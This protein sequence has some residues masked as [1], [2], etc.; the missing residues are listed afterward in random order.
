MEVG[1]AFDNAIR[2]GWKNKKL[3]LFGIAA[4]YSYSSTSDSDSYREI[5]LPVID[6][7]AVF[8]FVGLLTATISSFFAFGLAK[9][10]LRLIK[11]E[12]IT[13]KGTLEDA[14]YFF[15]R[16]LVI[17]MVGTIAGIA[18]I[19]IPAMAYSGLASFI[20]DPLWLIFLISFPINVLIGFIIAISA[21]ALVVHDISAGESLSR[22]WLSLRSNFGD[23]VSYWIRIFFVVLLYG[24]GLL[25]AGLVLVAVFVG[26]A[27]AIDWLA[28]VFAFIVGV[29]LAIIVAGVFSSANQIVWLQIY[30]EISGS[31]A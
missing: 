2:V 18:T 17:S 8:I 4:T 23:W 29:P 3:W 6:N 9:G 28:I 27:F 14:R 22:G 7:W 1:K 19:A 10:C 24:I 12:E 13:F 5:I 31:K 25:V 21:A 20:D 30:M 26:L 11:G 16:G 15:T